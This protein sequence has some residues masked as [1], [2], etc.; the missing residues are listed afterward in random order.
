MPMNDLTPSERSTRA[1][2]AVYERWARTTAADRIAATAPARQGLLDRFERLVDPDGLLDPAERARRADAA[3]KAHYLRMALKS[4]KARRQRR[5][6]EGALRDLVIENAEP[7]IVTSLRP[8]L[9]RIITAARTDARRFEHLGETPDPMLVLNERDEEVHE[10]FR[11]MGEHHKNY[12]AIVDARAALGRLGIRST[13]D[14]RG[15]FARI[16]NP[17][18]YYDLRRYGNKEVRPWPEDAPKRFVWL[19]VRDAQFWMPTPKE[20]DEKWRSI[21]GEAY[22]RAQRNRN[23][24]Q[25]FKIAFGG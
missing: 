5:G 12:S 18:D 7:I 17:E 25:A 16:S 13:L 4:A 2:I 15:L 9:D 14:E 21:F 19:L 20:Q 6:A 22:D 24:L 10:S 23:Q 3:R 11:A 8:A 1:R